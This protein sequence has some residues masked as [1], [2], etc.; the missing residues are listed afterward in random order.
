MTRRDLVLLPI[1]ITMLGLV[2]YSFLGSWLNSHKGSTREIHGASIKLQGLI[3]DF[4]AKTGRLPQSLAEID[5][6]LRP[7]LTFD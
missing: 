4:H 3:N 1:A 7:S 2:T 5:A 6:E